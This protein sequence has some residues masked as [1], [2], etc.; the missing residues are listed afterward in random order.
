MS[1][2]M[3]PRPIW[4]RLKLLSG[5]RRRLN[6]PVSHLLGESCQPWRKRNGILFG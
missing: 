1:H 3:R 2:L 5:S 4:E 6:T